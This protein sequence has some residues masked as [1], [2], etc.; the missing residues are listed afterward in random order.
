MRSEPPSILLFMVLGLVPAVCVTHLALALATSL[1][2][3]FARASSCDCCCFRRA[4]K[5][6]CRAPLLPARVWLAIKSVQLP[7][8]MCFDGD[9]VDSQELTR[10]LGREYL[11]R[12]A[13]FLLFAVPAWLGWVWALAQVLRR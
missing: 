11:R 9:L 13:T 7:C 1:S 8:P 4:T 3:A 2:A 6:R 10:A 5:R 12:A